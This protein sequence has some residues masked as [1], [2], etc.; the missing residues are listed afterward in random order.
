MGADSNLSK[1]KRLGSVLDDLADIDRRDNLCQLA[2]K[3]YANL[4]K[5]PYI[6]NALKIY[7]YNVFIRPKMI[8]NSST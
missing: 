2:L 1:V 6:N 5:N 4:W 7:I 8:Y 3:K